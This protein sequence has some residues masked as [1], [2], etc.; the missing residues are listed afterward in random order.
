MRPRRVADRKKCVKRVLA[1][2]LQTLSLCWG[3]A[4]S[5]DDRSRNNGTAGSRGKIKRVGV[6]GKQKAKKWVWGCF[7]DPVNHAVNWTSEMIRESF[8]GSRKKCGGAVSQHLECAHVSC[9]FLLSLP[10]FI[11]ILWR[12][13][14]ALQLSPSTRKINH[15]YD[16]IQVM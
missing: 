4:G 13:P 3:T 16:W 7:R 9:S 6:E 2:V 15:W 8:E 11:V 10:V 1:I 14:L 5:N 12:L